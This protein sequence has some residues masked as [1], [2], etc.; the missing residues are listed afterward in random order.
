MTRFEWDDKKADA[1]LHDRDISFEDAL[2]VF[3]DPNCLFEPD[4]YEFEERYRALGMSDKLLLLLVVHTYRDDD[5]T[6]VIR[7]ISA[8]DATP[9][10][11]RRY[12]NRKF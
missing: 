6:E 2:T 1:T 4:D 10:E 8:R 5:N 3:S 9:A 12:G 11:R 7:I